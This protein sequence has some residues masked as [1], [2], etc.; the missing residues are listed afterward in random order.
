MFSLH[1]L[2]NALHVITLSLEFNNEFSAVCVLICELHADC[3][4]LAFNQQDKKALRDF[5]YVAKVA[6][7]FLWFL[8]C[9]VKRFCFVNSSCQ[10]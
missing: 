2:R 8:P 7:T 3:M 9:E 6:T 10:L 4:F 1:V 5:T